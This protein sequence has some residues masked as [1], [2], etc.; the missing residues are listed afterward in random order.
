MAFDFK[1]ND[2]VKF[3]SAPNNY[4]KGNVYTV[5]KVNKTAK[6]VV[7][8]IPSLVDPTHDFEYNLTFDDFKR[9]DAVK[10]TAESNPET[11]THVDPPAFSK[12]LRDLEQ[13][14]LDGLTEVTET[15]AVVVS[16]GMLFGEEAMHAMVSAGDIESLIAIGD[17]YA[18]AAEMFA[19]LAEMAEAF[20]V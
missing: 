19:N 17:A 5:T 16:L 7:V 12:S 4:A 13:E 9:T 8:S 3:R 6:T 20:E 15:V 10:V 14:S 2:R 1:V 18:D 11:A